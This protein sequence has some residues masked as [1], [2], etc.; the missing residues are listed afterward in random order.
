MKVDLDY[1]PRDYAC[2]HDW[3]CNG[4]GGRTDTWPFWSMQLNRA[5]DIVRGDASV[6]IAIMDSGLD[7]RHPSLSLNVWQNLGEDF[8]QDGHTLEKV[9]MYYELD[10]GDLNGV[11]DDGGDGPVDDL[12]GW[13]FMDD[14]RDP[15]EELDLPDFCHGTMMGSI[16]S[17]RTDDSEV[18]GTASISWQSKLMALRAVWAQ[19][20]DFVRS[21]W[22]IGA[23]NYAAA[24]GADI[25]NM[26]FS[27]DTS[28]TT[29]H[30]AIIA[31]NNAGVIFVSSAGVRP[32]GPLGFG[33][34]LALIG[35]RYPQW[36]EEVICVA[37]VDTFG[38]KKQGETERV[39][40]NWGTT[41]DISGYSNRWD[42]PQG[43]GLAVCQYAKG[44]GPFCTEDTS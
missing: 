22:V 26:S 19:E 32:P 14:D 35:K 43:S 29:W 8:D 16:V 25:V 23:T 24:K 10:P 2:W 7:Y 5:W 34:D 20:D 12:I 36:W 40:S 15:F 3:Y 42:D 38:Y 1:I 13:D 17:S 30:E 33:S 41:V 37:A 44:P 39:R 9:G 4:T 27:T 31:A 28:T 18:G 6:V 11:D 21:S